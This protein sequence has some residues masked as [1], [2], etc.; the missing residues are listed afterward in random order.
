MLRKEFPSRLDGNHGRGQRTKTRLFS[1]LENRVLQSGYT[2][3]DF[4]TALFLTDSPTIFGDEMQLVTLSLPLSRF[5]RLPP[6]FFTPW[7]ALFRRRTV[8]PPPPR[9]LK[10]V[11]AD[12]LAAGGCMKRTTGAQ[13][14][15]PRICLTGRLIGDCGRDE[16]R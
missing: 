14:V 3:R 1:F 16:A 6:P 15:N 11:S 4:A 10:I 7:P 13:L 9:A 8:P 12:F 2:E 5:S